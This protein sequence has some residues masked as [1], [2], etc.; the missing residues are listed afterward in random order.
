MKPKPKHLGSEYAAQFKDRSI[1]EAYHH[2]PPYP[3]ETFEILSN[4]IT[5]EPKI[6][7]DVGCGT[8]YIARNLIGFVERID[9][10]DFSQHMI[11]KAKSLPRGDLSYINW[12]CGSVEEVPLHPPY[13][14][15]TA[16]Q[17]L[18]WMEWDVVLPRFKETL[19]PKGYLSIINYVFSSVPWDNKLRGIISRFST[20]QDFQPYDL[21]EELESRGLFQ[22]HGDKQTTPILFKQSIDEYVESFHSMNGFSR[23][24][25]SKEMA[26]AFDAAVKEMVLEY[27]PG[28]ELELQITAEIVWGMPQNL[29]ENNRG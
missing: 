13:A 29:L 25:M 8:G 6:V 9:A 18:H 7:L 26:E 12:I 3:P 16:G 20:N 1:V 17:S 14:L 21:I 2:R 5:D 10:V 27:C 4:L 11:E 22:K 28:E 24:R 23:E 15:V 19:T